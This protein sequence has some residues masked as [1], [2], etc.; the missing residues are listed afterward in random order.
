MKANTGARTRNYRSYD[1][2]MG[3]GV[4]ARWRGA[5]AGARM[6]WDKP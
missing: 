1:V 4:A 2:R 5:G 3:I 6:A